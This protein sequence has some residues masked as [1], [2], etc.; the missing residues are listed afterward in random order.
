[1]L[2]TISINLLH[3]IGV[4]ITLISTCNLT[5]QGLQEFLVYTI[6]EVINERV[7]AST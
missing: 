1:M 6:V 7:A 3:S 5:L 4:D 2:Q